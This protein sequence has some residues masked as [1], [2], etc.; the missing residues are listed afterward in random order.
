MLLPLLLQFCAVAVCVAPTDV[1]AGAAA[2]VVASVVP[3]TLLRCPLLA[4]SNCAAVAAN[5][6]ISMVWHALRSP[7]ELLPCVRGVAVIVV[8]VAAAFVVAV[9]LLLFAL[10]SL[11]SFAEM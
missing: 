9:V 5:L 10:L 8:V 2:A 6:R 11:D 4:A 1:D 7:L 3:T